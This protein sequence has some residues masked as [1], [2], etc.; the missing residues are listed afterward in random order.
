MLELHVSNG[1]Q[2]CLAAPQDISGAF[3]RGFSLRRYIEN[4]V[5][6]FLFQQTHFRKNREWAWQPAGHYSSGIFGWYHYHGHEHNALALTVTSLADQL[7]MEPAKVVQWVRTAAYTP[8][9]PCRCQSGKEVAKCCPVALYGYNRL[10]LD[11]G[12]AIIR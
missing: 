10:R 4:F 1:D 12:G 9:M 2:F 6:P 11:L 3:S 5:I 8:D 7:N